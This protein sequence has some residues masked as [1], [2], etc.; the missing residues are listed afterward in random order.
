[1]GGNPDL[2]RFTQKLAEGDLG[3]VSAAD[4]TAFLQEV[5]T[6][7][8]ANIETKA[9]EGGPFAAMR[10]EIIEE[11]RAQIAALIAKHGDVS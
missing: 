4:I 2:E 7:T 11:T 6:I 10:D 5:E 9:G 3:E 1:M 8:I